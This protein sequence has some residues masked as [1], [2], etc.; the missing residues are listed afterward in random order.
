MSRRSQYGS[1]EESTEPFWE[2]GHMVSPHT[3]IAGF[4][5]CLSLCLASPL[6]SLH[7]YATTAEDG[8][9]GL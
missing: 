7:R 6:L 5:F 1:R 3:S 4:S 9:G 8:M 2:M